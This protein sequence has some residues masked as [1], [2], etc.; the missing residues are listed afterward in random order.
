M[1][2]KL[3]RNLTQMAQ[4]A[5]FVREMGSTRRPSRASACS[6]T[7]AVN[8]IRTKLAASVVRGE[9]LRALGIQSAKTARLVIMLMKPAPA[10]VNLVREGGMAIKAGTSRRRVTA[11]RA[12][13]GSIL[14]RKG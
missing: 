2:V 13:R 10:C 4:L 9:R 1:F 3:A 8:L 7:Q 5:T 12:H 11:I 14:L 6:A